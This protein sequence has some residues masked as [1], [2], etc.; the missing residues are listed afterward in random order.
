LL[1]LGN[2]EVSLAAI[3]DPTG[4]DVAVTEAGR[5]LLPVEVKQ[6][7]VDEDTALRT[8]RRA[9]EQGSDKAL[10]VA[11]AVDQR[12]LDRERVR[13]QAYEE[14]G[15]VLVVWESVDELVQEV[16][17]QC[18]LT[19]EEIAA[20]LPENYLRRM[21]EHDVSLEG[22]QYFAD[23]VAALAAREQAE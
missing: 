9:R 1:D 19:A 22:R 23:L 15:V 21:E 16:A 18:P 3:N 7:A 10:L 17:V 8:A 14:H 2:D 4:V 5:L 6:K 13:R 11:L 20:E 12:S